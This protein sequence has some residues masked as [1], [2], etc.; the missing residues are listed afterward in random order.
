MLRKELKS[1]I[2]KM[3]DHSGAYLLEVMVGQELNV[4]PMISPGS[5]VSEMR[6]K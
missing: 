4:F 6:L 5:S 3:L 1:A 2:Q